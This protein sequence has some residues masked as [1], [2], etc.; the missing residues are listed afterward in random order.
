MKSV[1]NEVALFALV[2]AAVVV[3]SFIYW[4]LDDPEIPFPLTL[5]NAFV[6]L[7]FYGTFL[8]GLV[9]LRWATQH[10]QGQE[11]QQ[12]Q[13]LG[14]AM[15][16]S[17]YLGLSTFFYYLMIG[18]L[19]ALMVSTLLDFLKRQWAWLLAVCVPLA[20][21]A[22]DVTVKG[23]A[24]YPEIKVLFIA[25]N[26]LVLLFA[27]KVLME[28]QAKQRSRQLLRELQATQLLLENT[29]KRDERIR[30]ARDLHDSLGHKLTGLSLQL[31]LAKHT[32]GE[33]QT[34][35]LGLAQRIGSELLDD[36]RANVSEFREQ[37]DLDM[38]SIIATLV[39]DIP[40][41]EFEL[42]IEASG[43]GLTTRQAETLFRCTQEAITNTIKHS[44]ATHCLIEYRESGNAAT[45]RIQDNGGPSNS[46]LKLG[47]GL[48][49]MGERVSAVDGS[50]IFAHNQRGFE[51]S[52]TL[53][54]D[55]V[56]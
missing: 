55:L 34:Q 54:L 44:Q 23:M 19:F 50:A 32:E 47:N 18:L 29:T 5:L 9:I 36:I 14:F 42:S 56:S 46:G 35:A 13:W 41:I 7:I 52:I 25:I 45:L 43:S 21:G 4:Q 1:R 16:F 3:V 49:G 17:S 27:N 12:F 10:K 8:A 24:F 15:A 53:S 6:V 2:W 28:R 20:S 30:I 26:S 40:S 38:Q 37:N 51:V 31:Q 48:K 33:Q 22:Y 39:S 11:K